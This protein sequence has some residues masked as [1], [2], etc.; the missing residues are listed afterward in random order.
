MRNLI[1]GKFALENLYYSTLPYSVKRWIIVRLTPGI[2]SLRRHAS[3]K[4]TTHSR[5]II[6]ET[7]GGRFMADH[8]EDQPTFLERERYSAA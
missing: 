7:T 5:F 4:D 6:G 3:A 1:L 2:A 8:F